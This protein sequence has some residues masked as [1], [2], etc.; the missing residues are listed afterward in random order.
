MDWGVFF[1]FSGN[2]DDRH[3]LFVGRKIGFL[4]RLWIRVYEV[5]LLILF[6][7]LIYTSTIIFN[8]FNFML[9]PCSLA[10]NIINVIL[11]VIYTICIVFGV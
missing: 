1:G 9:F 10:I 4:L 3:F 5:Y 2:N 11:I 8:V 6:A 7:L